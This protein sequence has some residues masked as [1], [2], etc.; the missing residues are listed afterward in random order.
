MARWISDLSNASRSHEQLDSWLPC[1]LQLGAH[2]KAKFLLHFGASMDQNGAKTQK[3]AS[4][5]ILL[6]AFEYGM[7]DIR[8][9]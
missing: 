6:N 2:T 1:H 3:R 7:M 5:S 8:S 4:S 9:F